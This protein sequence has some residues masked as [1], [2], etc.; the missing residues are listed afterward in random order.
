MIFVG[1]TLLFGSLFFSC[2]ERP[3]E[4]GHI[5]ALVGG[6]ALDFDNYGK[7]TDDLENAVVLVSNDSIVAVGKS[8]EISIPENAKIVDLTGKYLVP[9]FIDGFAAMN[10][11]NYANAFLYMGVT[12][13]VGLDGGRRG[14][15]YW[16]ADP[17]PEI[18]KFDSYY[19]DAVWSE[20]EQ[21]IKRWATKNEIEHAIDSIAATGVKVLLV[22]YGVKPEQLETVVK[23]CREHDI[24]TIGELGHSKVADALEAGVQSFVHISR[25]SIDFVPE[26]IK[27]GYDDAPFGPPRVRAY[28]YYEDF[29]PEADS[30]LTKHAQLIGSS[31]AGLIPTHALFYPSFDFAKNPWTYRIAELIDPDSI[32]MPLNKETGKWTVLRNTEKWDTLFWSEKLVNNLLKIEKKYVQNN[33]KYLTGS[34]TDAFGAMPGISLHSEMEMLVRSGLTPREAIAAA[35]T[36]FC[37]IYEWD[38]IGQIKAGSEADIL[39]FDKNPVENLEHLNALNRLMLDGEII[40]RDSLLHKSD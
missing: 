5:I 26:T 23:K 17:A 38:H 16:E 7:S 24:V 27:K 6:T 9:G 14:P 1:L 28:Q 13:I 11:Q 18:Y 10:D 37:K 31:N 12:T 32:H 3:L 35:T 29:E 39:V 22:H 40:T 30:A 25:Y 34:G 20:E 2:K 8:D 21:M 19:G 4:P 15:I 33:A 36:N